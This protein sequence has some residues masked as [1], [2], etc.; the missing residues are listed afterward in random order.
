MAAAAIEELQYVEELL[1]TLR[2]RKPRERYGQLVN[3]CSKG[4]L[5]ILVQHQGR[6]RSLIWVLE[7][8]QT[9]VA[10]VESRG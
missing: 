1:A 7:V 6:A 5:H 2:A 9:D 10:G 8:H 4:I 3:Y